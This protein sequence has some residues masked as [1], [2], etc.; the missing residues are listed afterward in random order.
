MQPVSSFE[1]TEIILHCAVTQNTP[2][3]CDIWRFCVLFYAR[4]EPHSWRWGVPAHNFTVSRHFTALFLKTQVVWDV[5]WAAGTDWD[6]GTAIVRNAGNFI[7]WFVRQR[8]MWKYQFLETLVCLATLLGCW[9]LLIKS[10]LL[11][12]AD[13][14]LC[15]TTLCISACLL[16]RTWERWIWKDM[17]ENSRGLLWSVCLQ[18]G[19]EKPNK[20]SEDGDLRST[21]DQ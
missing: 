10:N 5:T 8:W 6:E 15:W 2:T 12:L 18:T 13:S 16:W 9:K 3:V 14:L 17:E 4:L 19:S 21:K 1:T 20:R 11:V 7:S